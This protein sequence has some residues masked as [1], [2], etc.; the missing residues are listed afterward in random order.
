MTCAVGE[1]KSIY[2]RWSTYPSKFRQEE[3]KAIV[4]NKKVVVSVNG[5]L[6]SFP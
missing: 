3:A 6:E 5:M 2:L 1:Q 4:F